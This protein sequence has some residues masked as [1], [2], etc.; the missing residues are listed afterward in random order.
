MRTEGIV[1]YGEKTALQWGVEDGARYTS[2]TT[3][4]HASTEAEFIRLAKE[5]A[6][7]RSAAL[8][9]HLLDRKVAASGLDFTGAHGRQQ[10]NAIDTLGLGGRLGVAIGAAG[11]GKTAMLKPLVAAWRE[12]GREV[13]GASL[14]WKQADDLVD[15]GIDRRNVKAYSVL[16]DGLKDGSIKAGPQTVVAV[17][18]WGLIG[19]RQALELLRLRAQHGFTIVGL[20]DDKQAQSIQAGAIIDLSR[21]ALGAEQIPQILTTVRQQTERERQIVGLFRDGMAADALDMK[22]ADGTAEMAYGG[23][24][25]V[26]RRV[27]ALYAERLQATRQAQRLRLGPSGRPRRRAAVSLGQG[28]VR[29]GRARGQH[30]ARHQHPGDAGVPRGRQC[31][32]TISTGWSRSWRPTMRCS[33]FRRPRRRRWWRR[34]PRPPGA[35][36]FLYQYVDW[37]EHFAPAGAEPARPGAG[38]LCGGDRH[39]RAAQESGAAAEGAGDCRSFAA[40]ACASW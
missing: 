5:A 10:R 19:T 16:I 36:R 14:A 21:R 17:D 4:L 2:V 28:R 3:A 29:R 37:P 9:A 31:G 6:A 34:F 12:Q 35:S 22:R 27:A 26:V 33:A 38:A 30:R 24:D 18:E 7:D 11:A 8:P 23:R 13:I 32:A 40:R 1:Q 39:D 20:G 15:A 25:G